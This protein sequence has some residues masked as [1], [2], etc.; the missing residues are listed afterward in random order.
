MSEN[1]CFQVFDTNR[2]PDHD[3]KDFY[4]VPTLKKA[5]LDSTAPSE[6]RGNLEIH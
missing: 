6:L 4:T 3:F 2:P 5:K 1:L